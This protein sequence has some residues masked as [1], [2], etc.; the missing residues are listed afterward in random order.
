MFRFKYS[1]SFLN[2]LAPCNAYCRFQRKSRRCLQSPTNH[3]AG[4]SNHQ[5]GA[6]SGISAFEPRSRASLSLS[7]LA[8]LSPYSCILHLLVQPP[9]KEKHAKSPAQRSTSFAYIRSSGQKGWLQSLSKRLP[10]AVIRSGLGKQST[11][12]ARCFLPLFQPADTITA[13]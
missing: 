6:N 11:L 10:V 2:W 12:R 13:A 8:S 9:P 3:F 5:A 1:A 7:Y 4:R